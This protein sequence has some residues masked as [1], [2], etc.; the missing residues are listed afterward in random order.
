MLSLLFLGVEQGSGNFLNEIIDPPSQPLI[1]AAT[2]SLEKIGAVV[3]SNSREERRLM[4]TPLGLHLARIPAPLSLERVSFDE[5]PSPS[6]LFDYSTHST[7]FCY[8]L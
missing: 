2:F 4:L 3:A 6:Y 8:I 1:D 5:I 7:S